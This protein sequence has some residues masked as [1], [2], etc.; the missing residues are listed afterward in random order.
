MSPHLSS[1]FTPDEI[2]SFI[3]THSHEVLVVA[4]FVACVT[5]A[6]VS[7]LCDREKMVACRKACFPNGVVECSG[8]FATCDDKGNVKRVGDPD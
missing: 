7:G 2:K 6:I 5:V 8:D 4:I 1:H 3:A